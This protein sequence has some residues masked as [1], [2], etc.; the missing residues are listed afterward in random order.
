MW[1]SNSRSVTFFCS[2]NLLVGSF[3]L[4]RYW[5]TSASRFSFPCSTS[6]SA[7]T[8]VTGMPNAWNNQVLNGERP[9]NSRPVTIGDVDYVANNFKAVRSGL[10]TCKYA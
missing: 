3:Q 2:V 4:L 5:L 8:A 7:A 10:S 1:L 6:R 9:A